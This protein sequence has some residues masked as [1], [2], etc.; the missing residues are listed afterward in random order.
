MTNKRPQHWANDLTTIL[1]A[2]FG[3]SR[4][5][6][7]VIDLAKDYSLQLY[8]DDPITLIVG[9]PLAGFEGAIAPAKS[10]KN[11]WGIFYNSAIQSEGRINFTLAHEFGHYLIHR[12]KYPN[13]LECSDRDVIISDAEYNQIESEANQFAAALLMP[14]DTFR[15]N[16]SDTHRPTLDDIGDCANLFGV[17]LIAATLRWLE[18]TRRR[19]CLVVSRDGFVLWARSSKSA[20]KSGLFFKTSGRAPIPVP[21]SSLASNRQFLSSQTNE[22]HHGRDVWFPEECDE[23]VLFSDSYDLTLSLLH[24]EERVWSFEEEPDADD[25]FDRMTQFR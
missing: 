25:C 2:A 13:G 8:P 4:F 15:T 17:S 18:Y 12:T 10:P 6:V 14:L 3:P 24:F 1:N 19:A 9:K 5:P 16:I 7:K 20:L 11:G 22:I 21:I 23:I